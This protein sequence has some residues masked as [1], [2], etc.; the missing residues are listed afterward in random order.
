MILLLAISIGS[1]FGT[2]I[3][4]L[5]RRSVVK[6]VIGL[7]LLGHAANLLIF[8]M[9]RP[10]RGRAP[11]VDA[12]SLAP[13]APFTDP[14]PTALVLTAIVIG[15][16][17]LSYTVVLIKRVYYSAGTDDLASLNTTDS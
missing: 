9:S 1:L 15:F 17:L 11:L 16:G 5:L 3:Y 7:A 6:L 13:D 2:G 8:T 10:V 14:L 4:M 12:G